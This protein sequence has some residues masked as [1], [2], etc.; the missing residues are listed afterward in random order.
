M[1][2][3]KHTTHCEAVAWLKYQIILRRE[4]WHLLQGHYSRVDSNTK[5]GCVK[6][7]MTFNTAS[8]CPSHYSSSINKSPVEIA[9]PE[10]T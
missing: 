3:H 1:C 2:C 8:S 9:S 10:A 4:W 5:K 6:S 7:Q